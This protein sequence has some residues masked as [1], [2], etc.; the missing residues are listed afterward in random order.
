MECEN[1]F[2]AFRP[3]APHVGMNPH[4]ISPMSLRD[5]VWPGVRLGLIP[6]NGYIRAR[7]P[8][9]CRDAM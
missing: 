4:A 2:F 9:S 8:A 7:E 6:C 3:P 1:S 5:M